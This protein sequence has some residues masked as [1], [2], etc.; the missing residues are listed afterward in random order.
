M[1]PSADGRKELIRFLKFSVVG[2]IGAV[3]DFGTFNML[4][5]VIRLQS[6]ISSV[7]SFTAAIISNF[8]WNRFWTYPDSRSKTIRQQAIQFGLVNVVGLGI[9]T[10]IFAFSEGYLI[11]LAERLLPILPPSLPPAPTSIFPIEAVVLGRNMALA[12]AVIV[13]L[14]WNFLIN[15]LWTY[16]D[17]S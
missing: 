6:L 2:T 5:S 13:V 17:V 15:R 3:V 10:P 9:R 7:L 12:L 11:R 4:T 1:R 16:S 14:F 8:I